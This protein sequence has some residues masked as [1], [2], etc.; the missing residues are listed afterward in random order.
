VFGALCP[1]ED[2]SSRVLNSLKRVEVNRRHAIEDGVTVVQ[3]PVDHG[4]C[5]GICSVLV[6][7]VLDVS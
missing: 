6:N 5:D 1:C 3:S 2:T 7:M 4:A